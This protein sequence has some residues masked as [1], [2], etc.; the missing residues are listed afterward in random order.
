M[1]QDDENAVK[2]EAVNHPQHYG[3][4]NPYEVIKVLR[5]WFPDGIP[6]NIGNTIKY[7][8][9]AG[10]KDPAKLVED[11]EKGRWYLDDEIVH[12]KKHLP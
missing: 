10:K 4:D 6:F 9:R 1:P 5:A 12:L 8:A 7:L 3:G 2:P 11:L